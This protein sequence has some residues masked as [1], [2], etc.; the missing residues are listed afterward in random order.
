MTVLK[1]NTCMQ[2][3]FKILGFTT[4]IIKSKLQDGLGPVGRNTENARTLKKNRTLNALGEKS[5]RNVTNKQLH[6]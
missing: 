1:T 3:F 5:M 6:P 4:K 2:I